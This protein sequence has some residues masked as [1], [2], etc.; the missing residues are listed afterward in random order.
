MRDE[1]ALALRRVRGATFSRV[2]LSVLWAPQAPAVAQ[3]EAHAQHRAEMVRVSE[4]RGV[5]DPVVLQAMRTVPRHEF[6]PT[7]AAS[8]AYGDHPLPIGYGQTISQP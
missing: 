8:L 6:M 4:D 1:T 7:V 3:D 2:V 5:R